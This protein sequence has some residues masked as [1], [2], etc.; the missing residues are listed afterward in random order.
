MTNNSTWRVL[1]IKGISALCMT[2]ALSWLEVEGSFLL[3]M[4]MRGGLIGGTRKRYFHTTG[5][6]GKLVNIQCPAM[7]TAVEIKKSHLP[8][9]QLVAEFIHDRPA[10]NL[11]IITVGCTSDE[12]SARPP[13]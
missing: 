9:L 7:V 1:G 12:N 11:L 4:E 5:R 8:N 10:M 2:L 6:V 13:G 3:K